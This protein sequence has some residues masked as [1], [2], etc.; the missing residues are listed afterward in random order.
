MTKPVACTLT[1]KQAAEQILDWE[2]MRSRAPATSRSGHGVSMT[3]PGFLGAAVLA[4]VAREKAC[5]DFL[6]LD[7]TTQVDSIVKLMITSDNPDAMP[8]I[9]LLAG[10]IVGDGSPSSGGV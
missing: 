5:C 6:D 1:T 2:K 7:V 3:F 9:D 4:F 10:L 8:I